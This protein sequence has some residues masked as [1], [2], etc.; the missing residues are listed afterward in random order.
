[1]DLFS[2]IFYFIVAIFIL[3]TVHEFGHFAAAKLFGMRVEKFYIGFDFWN[4]KLWSTHRGETEYGI[5]A[6]PLG[7]YVKI[8]GIIDES[9]DTDFQSR[10]PEPWEFRSKP[11]WQRLIVLA[12]G[13]IMN[14]VLA[15]VIFIG[16]ALVYGE[17]KTPITTGAYVEAGSVF[18]DMG[19]RTGD[20]I[21]KVNGKPVKYWDEALDP[22]LFTHHPLTY[23]VLRDGKALTFEAPSDIFSRLNGVQVPS[24]RPIVPPLVAEAFADYPAAKAGLTAGALVTKIGGQEIYDWQ[25]VI[26]NVSA[27]ADKPIEIEWKVFGN[28]KVVEINADKIRKMGVAHTSSIV[29]N[30]QGKIGITL[31]Q[32]DLREYAELGFFE[33]IVAGSKQTWKMTAMTVKGFG[34]L[35][36]GKEDIRRSVGGP[37]KIAKLA[38]QSAEQGPGSFLLF[39]AM[40]SISL[41]F[42]N[43]LPVPALDGGQIVINAVEG[44]MGRE[45]P[46]NIKLRIQQIG[47]TALLILIGFIIFNDIVNP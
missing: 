42:L 35:L 47:M 37:I 16:L 45:V 39:L 26:D 46:L 6:I 9:F 12:A 8:S 5:G 19:I 27:N 2:T 25:Q 33:A 18:E 23:T 32:T 14:M 29:P 43:I 20:K 13:V 44:I 1:M 36:S 30:E 11:V 21:V 3:V 4:L 24:M 28:G 15:A 40:L 34:R 10:A 41:A 31:D 38:G 7:G 22:E 17:S